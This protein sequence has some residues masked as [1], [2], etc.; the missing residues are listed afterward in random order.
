MKI[1]YAVVDNM[2]KLYS[3]VANDLVD[4]KIVGWFQGGSEFGPRAL[5]FRSILTNPM[6]EDAKKYLNEKVKFREWWRP[7]APVILEEDLNEWFDT[8]KVSP[9]MLFSAKVSCLFID[10]GNKKNTRK[11][12]LIP[13]VVHEDGTARYQT[14][15]ENQ[16]RHLYNLLL[17]FKKLTQCP[18]L[19]NTSF[20]VGGEPIVETPF[21]AYETFKKTSIDVLVM[22]NVYIK[23]GETKK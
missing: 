23:K 22:N 7:Y 17:E 9:Y 14:V 13:G 20:N 16:N 10:D 15:N 6:R 18:I 19:L 5:G 11:R 8:N 2:N 21:D 1:Q 4:N 12:D 3:K